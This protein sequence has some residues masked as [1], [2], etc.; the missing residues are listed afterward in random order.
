METLTR[1]S[2]KFSGN[3][4]ELKIASQ[5]PLVPFFKGGIFYG[6]FNPLFE[7]EGKGRFANLGN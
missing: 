3:D 5:I 4:R 2:E 6:V 1:P 7:K